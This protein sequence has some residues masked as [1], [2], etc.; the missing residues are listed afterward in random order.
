MMAAAHRYEGTVN[1][2]MGD[3]IMA[4]F[5]APIAQKDHVARA[6]YAALAMPASVKQYPAEV[7]RTRGGPSTSESG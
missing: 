6:C 7:Q 3:W 5:E 1:R 2:V 4:L